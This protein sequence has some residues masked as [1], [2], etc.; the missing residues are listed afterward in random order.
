MTPALNPV[1]LL[2]PPGFNWSKLMSVKNVD[3]DREIIGIMLVRKAFT[4]FVVSALDGDTSSRDEV[5][6]KEW[7]GGDMVTV[8]M[9]H[10]DVDRRLGLQ[11]VSPHLSA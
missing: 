7:E 2:V 4:E 1:I 11:T 6:G 10:Q 3:L 8:C 5:G 9:T